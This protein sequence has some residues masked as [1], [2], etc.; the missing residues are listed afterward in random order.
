MTLG[1]LH[2]KLAN[3]LARWP[4]MRYYK[5]SIQTA[6]H[7]HIANALIELHQPAPPPV[8]PIPVISTEEE[9]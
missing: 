6:D 2:D 8:E 4:Q 1:E 9:V 7:V 3:T 5:V